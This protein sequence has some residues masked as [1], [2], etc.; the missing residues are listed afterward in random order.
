MEKSGLKSFAFKM[1]EVS[2]QTPEAL[3]TLTISDLLMKIGTTDLGLLK[4]DIEG[5]E[6]AL[7]TANYESWIDKFRVLI[8]EVHGEKAKTAVLSVMANRNFHVKDQGELVFI[9]M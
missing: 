4:L 9:K 7:F 5:A 1:K 2:P 6:E 8:V 3:P